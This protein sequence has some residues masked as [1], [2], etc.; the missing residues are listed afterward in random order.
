MIAV[1]RVGRFSIPVWIPM[2]IGAL[3]M[4]AMQTISID[5]AYRAVKMDVIIFLLGMFMMVA[6][7]ERAGVI[8]HITVSILKRTR[9]MDRLLL[10]IL[11]VMGTLSA[12]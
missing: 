7:L 5:D 6:V 3:A 4:L 2:L 8:Q 12:L 11:V 1:R 10:F 9:N